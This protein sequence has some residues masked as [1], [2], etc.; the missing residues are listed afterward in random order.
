M[1]VRIARFEGIDAT[2]FDREVGQID[3]QSS[4][5]PPP[6]LEGTKRLLMLVDRATGTALGLTFFES[7][8]AM[9]RADEALDQMSMDGQG[10][11]TSVEM[12]EVGL[13]KSLGKP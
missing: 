2:E 9:R 4:G 13:D 12:Y 11:R 7:E 1:F 3:E 5:E 10:R 8:E 6:G